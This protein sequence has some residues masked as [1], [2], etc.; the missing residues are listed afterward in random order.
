[1]VPSTLE[2]SVHAHWLVRFNL[3][4]HVVIS[5][6]YD[7]EMFHAKFECPSMYTARDMAPSTQE[8][9]VHVHYLVCLN[10]FKLSYHLEI[11]KGGFM[12]SFDVLACILPEIFNLAPH[13]VSQSV[14]Q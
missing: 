9:S 7:L 3:V 2:Y 10:L 5:S 8:Y 13:G 11:F 14:S 12:P 4:N 6:R 1:M